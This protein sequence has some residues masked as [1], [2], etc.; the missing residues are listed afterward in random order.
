MSCR[1]RRSVPAQVPFGKLPLALAEPGDRA[2][3]AC[4]A[5]AV[6]VQVA[7]VAHEGTC[8]HSTPVSGCPSNGSPSSR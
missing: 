6:A 5:A 1:A 8:G 4:T 2:T 7:P 3:T